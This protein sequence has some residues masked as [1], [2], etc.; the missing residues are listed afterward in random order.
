MPDNKKTLTYDQSYGL[1]PA[2][3]AGGDDYGLE[4]ANKHELE[5]PDA[6]AQ[7]HAAGEKP[8]R[9]AVANL[10]QTS[11]KAWGGGLAG[12]FHKGGEYL[13]RKAEESQ[14]E[15][16]HHVGA[17]EE[18][19]GPGAFQ[20]LGARTMHTVG[21]L[22]EPKSIGIMA[23]GAVAP[24]IVGPALVAHGLYTAG[25][26]AKGAVEGKPEEVGAALGGLSEAAGGGAMTG[27]GVG[28]W[29]SKNPTPIGRGAG[30]VK[31]ITGRARLS[32][33]EAS[34]VPAAAEFQPAYGVTPG[35]VLHHAAQE[36]IKLT[37][38]QGTQLPVSK[39]VQAIG[40]RDLTGSK[41]LT[42]GIDRNAA[43]FMKSVTKFA[44]QVDPKRL[45]TSDEAAGEAIK[46]ATETAKDV[47]HENASN[48]YK[49]LAK[50][51]VDPS[52]IAKA[53]IKNRG[54]LPT[55]IEDM[56]LSKVPRDMKAHVAEIMDP[57]GTAPKLTSEQAINLRSL[58]LDLGRTLGADLPTRA[59]GV[60]K[61]MSK[62][63]DSAL[64][65]DSRAAGVEKE[66]RG[67]NAGWKA[68]IEKYGEKSSPLYR[69]LDQADPKKITRDLMNRKSAADV[70]L[71][72][73][74]KLDPALD[75]LRSR[76][77]ADVA[78]RKF[79]VDREGLG[80]YSHAF[81]NTLFG[82]EGVRTLYIKSEIGRRFN[83]QM[84]PSG[85]SNVMIGES[86]IVH[87]TPSKIG[88]MAGSS[89]L[90]RPRTATDYLPEHVYRARDVGN[91]QI[92]PAQ[93]SHATMTLEDAQRLA[94]GRARLSGPQEI[95]RIPLSRFGPH[96][97]DVRQGP[98]GSN[99][100]KFNRQ[101]GSE[102]YLPLEAEGNPR[103][104][105]SVGAGAAGSA[106]ERRKLPK[107]AGRAH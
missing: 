6:A 41:E 31:Q 20:D 65:S 9:T 42:E 83:F 23:A 69:I 39:M 107:P 13:N 15:R 24:E 16:L 95:Q 52:P 46:Q 60:F 14:A 21:G 40:E 55:G 99:W 79:T 17:G 26:H 43:A 38:G 62:A 66:W 73:N 25:S 84:N 27:A 91:P 47:S 36:G 12:A 18:D 48:A 68:H 82:P 19:T 56:I 101:L 103:R 80:G 98:H 75:A 30:I 37:P 28:S 1:E 53:W 71:L 54:A 2:G 96:E 33:V 3:A 11:G 57:S 76:V 89:R 102:D 78:K 35:E 72:K 105:S 44:D 63:A 5:I 58:F 81:L 29:G 45:G 104:L 97:Y 51:D 70:E 106:I 22:L 87:P 93:H 100:I 10:D 49:T 90:S 74:E 8:L 67:A 32:P 59:Q 86:Q 34:T 64:E 61:T 77:I 88:L 92:N 85:T 94:P 50:F 7:A 4:P